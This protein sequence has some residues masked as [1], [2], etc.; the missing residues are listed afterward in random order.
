MTVDRDIVIVQGQT[1]TEFF[2]APDLVEAGHG[3]R[4]HIR[5]YLG[6]TLIR[7]GLAHD[8]PPN[9]RLSFVDGGVQANLG[10]SLSTAWD[11]GTHAVRRWVY[12][13][14]YYA[15]ANIDDVRV[16]YA[17]VC[18]V[19]STATDENSITASEPV[20]NSALTCLRF[21]IEQALTDEQKDRACANSGAVRVGTGGDGGAT[22]ATGPTG[23][24]GPAGATGATGSAGATG[25]TGPTGPTGATGSNGSNGAAGA[26]GATG[27]TGATGSNGTNG[28][29]G[30]TGATGPTGPTGATGSAGATGATGATGSGGSPA[31]SGTELQYRD[32]SALGAAPGSA[33]DATNGR[34]GLGTS[35]PAAVLHVKADSASEPALIAQVASGATADA[36]KWRDNSGADVATMRYD[37]ALFA[38]YVTAT[39]GAHLGSVSFSGQVITMGG[40]Q[41][42]S[43]NSSTGTL[44][45]E[46]N[47]ANIA[48]SPAAY[49]VINGLPTSASGLPTGA[50][51]NDAGTLKVA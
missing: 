39:T 40:V 24:T 12:S 41:S 4:M 35:S 16:L 50:L 42:I 20:P 51:W 29:D 19:K 28:A 31:G 34:I 2:E 6:A 10:A 11:L 8:T 1:W 14:E 22:G 21:D 37:G 30:A 38:S 25:S 13:I 36:Q 7:C 47:A 23:P 45:I 17:G 3:L 27:P 5:E 44:T 32:G 18:I 33:V 26:T 15:L 9:C 46:T 48:L 49:V 43:R